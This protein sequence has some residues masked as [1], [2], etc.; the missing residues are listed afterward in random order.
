MAD[1]T[2]DTAP[3]PK[4][5][6]PTPPAPSPPPSAPSKGDQGFPEDTPLTEMTDAQ[7]AAYW[8]S[9]ARRHEAVVKSRADYDELKAQAAEAKKLRKE[10]ESETEKLIRE[11]GEQAAA[12]ARA[13][14]APQLV[15]A[16]FR[17]AAAGGR[18]DAARLA[19]L[20][21]DIDLTRFLTKDGTV[22]VDRITAKVE[23]WAPAAEQRKPAPKPDPTQGA[24][25]TKTSG[26]DVGREMYESRRKPA[27]TP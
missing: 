6:T 4:A 17:A 13:E 16:E 18:I 19:T 25:N 23:A 27:R 5:D 26:T 10:R 7:Q 9:H 11:A 12:A 3:E 8:K 15:M 21:E 14:V 24:R 1:D 20:T 22:D 2:P